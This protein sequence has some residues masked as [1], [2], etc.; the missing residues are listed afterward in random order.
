MTTLNFAW[1]YLRVSSEDQDLE[2]QEAIIG[3]IG[4]VPL[5]FISATWEVG[6]SVSWVKISVRQVG[7]KRSQ[8]TFSYLE[9]I[10]SRNR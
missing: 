1:V 9:A 10:G 5:S 8:L 3:N 4:C 7:E 2:R 6:K